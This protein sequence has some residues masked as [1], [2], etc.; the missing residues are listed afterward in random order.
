MYFVLKGCV[1]LLRTAMAFQWR[2]MIKN[3]N[4]FHATI[5]TAKRWQIIIN[6][7]AQILLHIGGRRRWIHSWSTL[8]G[9]D[10]MAAYPTHPQPPQPPSNP[11]KSKPWRRAARAAKQAQRVKTTPTGPP[12]P[13]NHPSHQPKRTAWNTSHCHCLH[14]REN[15][16]PFTH[17]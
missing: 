14:H 9:D 5:I 7:I 12:R 1:I 2:W 4:K 8:L 13:P 15:T 17:E 6:N 3:E 11:S 10:G 16:S